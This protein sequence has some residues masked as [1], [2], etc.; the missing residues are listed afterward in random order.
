MRYVLNHLIAYTSV[1]FYVVYFLS[2]IILFSPT[3]VKEFPIPHADIIIHHLL[4]IILSLVTLLKYPKAP[5]RIIIILVGYAFL[6]ELIQ[7][8]FIP[9]RSFELVDLLSDTLGILIGLFLAS[10]SLKNFRNSLKMKE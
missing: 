7:H 4:F 8:Y 1:Y 3:R 6:S 2:F 10:N 5:G 9:G